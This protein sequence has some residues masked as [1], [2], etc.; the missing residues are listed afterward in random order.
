MAYEDPRFHAL[1]FFVDV[2]TKFMVYEDVL[3]E[4]DESEDGDEDTS[5]NDEETEDGGDE[6]TWR[7]ALG[8]KEIRGGK[9]TRR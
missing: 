4:D 9:R 3:E 2:H 6:N 8:R 1:G 5:D 7:R